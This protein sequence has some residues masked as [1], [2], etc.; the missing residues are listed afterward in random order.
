MQFPT[1]QAIP[2]LRQTVDTFLGYHRG[3][4]IGLGEFADMKNLSGRSYPALSPRKKRGVYLEVENCGAILAKD[5]L[6]CI[7]GSD[8]VMGQYLVNLG[9][10]PGE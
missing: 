6:C 10:T 4:R 2:E 7:D 9:L 1:L 8:F 5:N 3:S